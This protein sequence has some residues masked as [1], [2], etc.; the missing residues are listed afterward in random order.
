[1][2]KKQKSFKKGDSVIISAR[3]V[4]FRLSNDGQECY[5]PPSGVLSR[6]QELRRDKSTCA[7]LLLAMCPDIPGKIIRCNYPGSDVE[8]YVIDFMGVDFFVET[9]N[10]RLAKTK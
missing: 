10:I 8:N 5:F 7:M 9:R 4:K 1:M 6:E 2:L 3:Y